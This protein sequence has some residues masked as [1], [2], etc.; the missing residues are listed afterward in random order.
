MI[1]TKKVIDIALDE[2]GYLEKA[3]NKDLDFKKANVGYNNYTKYG[4]DMHKLYPSIMDFPAA[5]CDCFVDWCFYKAYGVANA[6]ALLG[7][8]FNDYT[9][10]SSQLYKNKN[11]WYSSPKVGDQI[12][13]KDSSGKICHT[14]LVYKVDDKRVYTVE[15]NTSSTEGVV[16]NGGGV[17]KRSYSLSYNK[18]AGY[19]RPKY[20]AY[21]EEGWVKDDKG[22]WYRYA[23]GSYPKSCWKTIKGKDYYFKADG[24]MASD[25]FIKSEDYDTNF[26]LY[27][28]DSDGAWDGRTYR[29]MEDNKGWWLAKLGSTSYYKSQWAK[30]DGKW[31]Y[32]KESGYMAVGTLTID[33]KIYSFRSDGSLV[34]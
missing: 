19:G 22:W 10:A 3:S 25:E 33:G 23:D 18:I 24:Y 31:Y 20:D 32:F 11:A 17:F 7:G 26:K 12:F 4:R 1:Y 14:G 30:V 9:I 5:W 8:D 16:A 21:C 2:V 27:Y 13:F 34:E 29:W 6:K 15:G 28:V